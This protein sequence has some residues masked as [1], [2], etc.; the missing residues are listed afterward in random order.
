MGVLLPS[1]PLFGV[2][3]LYLFFSVSLTFRGLR[4][5]RRHVHL[6]TTDIWLLFTRLDGEVDIS[7][8]SCCRPFLFPLDILGGVLPKAFFLLQ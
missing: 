7:I 8:L 1:L 2:L 6:D 3:F 4:I 5:H